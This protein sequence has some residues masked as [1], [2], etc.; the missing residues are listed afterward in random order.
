MPVGSSRRR[1]RQSGVSLLVACMALVF[2]VPLMGLVIDV[3]VLYTVRARLQASVDGASLAAARA[4]NLGQTTSDQSSS[5]KQNAVNWFYANFPS[6]NWS[7]YNTVM[8]QSSVNVFDDP[9]NPQLRNVTVAASTVAPTYFMRWFGTNAVTVTAS[10]NASRRDVVAMLVLDRSGSMCQPTGTGPCSSANTTTPCAAMI[11]AAKTFTGQF[12][13]NR[14]RI[15]LLTFSDGVYMAASPSTSFQTTLG[16]SNTAGSSSGLIDNINCNGGTGTAAAVTVAYNE[17]YKMNLPGALNLLVLETD[18][19]PN[20][21]VYNWWDNTN[22]VAGIASG[23]G[24]KDSAGK[25]Y[26]NSGWRN[27]ASIPSWTTGYSMNTNGTGFMAD[28]PAGAIGGYYSQDPPYTGAIV[29]Y[30]PWQ[31][32]QSGSSN[33]IAVN[34]S[35]C[36]FSAGTYGQTTSDDSDF[37]WLPSTDVYGNAINPSNAYMSVTTSSGRITLTGNT[38]TDWNNTR[39]AAF[40]ATDNAAYRARTNST[41][42]AYLFVIG[43]G[44]NSTTAPPDYILLQR[45]ANDPTGDTFNA[46]P[47]YDRCSTEPTCITYSNQPGGHFVFSPTT[48]QLT[49]AFLQISS[50]VLR[51][52]R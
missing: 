20:T 26:A 37:K 16:Y 3:G 10:G 30:G 36:K 9:G 17:L 12:A 14:D 35:G 48:A 24:C 1:A 47:K 40:N 4:L 28:I 52:S 34:G 39:A 45:M 31:T 18:G 21:L 51:L 33:S 2:I 41:L 46:T 25:T 42:P 15:G 44:G 23:S 49:Q 27:S 7:T 6:G 29:L 43:L 50:Q 13:A 8:D 22:T 19:L 5:A 11:K 32:G 38:N